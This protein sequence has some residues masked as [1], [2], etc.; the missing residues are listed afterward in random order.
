MPPLPRLNKFFILKYTI[1]LKAHLTVDFS[2]P[3]IVPWSHRGPGVHNV[4]VWWSLGHGGPTIVVQPLNK[5]KSVFR[6]CVE[7][8][9]AS[10]SFL[11]RK[12][13]IKALR[14]L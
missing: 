13:G 11:S 3:F 5:D 12:K 10:V 4:V 2:G 8:P 7:L 14:G 9:L 6:S 1:S